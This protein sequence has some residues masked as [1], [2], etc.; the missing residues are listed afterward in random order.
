[1]SGHD[2]NSA[3]TDTCRKHVFSKRNQTR[4]TQERP[5]CD[6]D[7]LTRSHTETKVVGGVY[8]LFLSLLLTSN[9]YTR[10]QLLCV[11][12]NTWTHNSL[13]TS[14]VQR[15]ARHRRKCFSKVFLV[16]NFSPFADRIVFMS[17]RDGAVRRTIT[18]IERG[19]NI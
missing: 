10:F 6:D 19:D 12:M 15:G 2:S 9:N 13:G 1:L 5:S 16:P 3:N 14:T 4:K 7:G 11:Y 17:G 18:S 8:F